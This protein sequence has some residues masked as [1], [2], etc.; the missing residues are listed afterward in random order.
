[1][2]EIWIA[3]MAFSMG[4]W[5]GF[6][7]SAINRCDSKGYDL[8]AIILLVSSIISIALGGFAFSQSRKIGQKEDEIAALKDADIA[9]LVD[10][11]KKKR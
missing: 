4:G 3:V 2:K 10:F 1:M 6:L 7:T 11:T 5:F 8:W 9:N